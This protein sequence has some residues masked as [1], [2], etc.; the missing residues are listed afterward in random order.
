[1]SFLLFIILLEVGT[2]TYFLYHKLSEQDTN[3][4]AIEQQLLDRQDEL[5]RSQTNEQYDLAIINLLRSPSAQSMILEN[6]KSVPP[7]KG[8][9][10]WDTRTGKAV[11]FA[12]FLPD[13][14]SASVYQIWSVDQQNRNILLGQFENSHRVPNAYLIDKCAA[15]PTSQGSTLAVSALSGHLDQQSSGHLLVLGSTE[16]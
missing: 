10:I 14:T 11:L 6:K 16:K 3:R 8:K 12:N 4:A 2:V 9:F 15:P 7:F 5:F 1:M 13:Q